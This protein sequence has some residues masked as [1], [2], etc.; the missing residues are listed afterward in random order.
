MECATGDAVYIGTIGQV[1]GFFERGIDGILS[2]I[3]SAILGAAVELFANLGD[4]PTIGDETLNDSIQL[5]TN[6]LVVTIAVASLLAAA[7][8]M[9]LERKGQPM[10]V[11][12]MGLVRMVLTVSAAWWVANWLASEADAYSDHLY[13]EGIKAQLKLIANCGT[14][15]LTAFLLI[16]IG[17]LLLIAGCI[18]VILMYIRLGVMVLLTGTLPLAAAASMSEW[19][20]GWWRK[21]IA[22]MVA[23]LAF[24]PV[25]GL[26]MYSGAAMIGATGEMD[27]TDNSKHYKLAGAAVLLMAAVAL[28]ALMR[29]VVPAMASLGSRDGVG[30]GVSAGAAGAGAVASGAKRIAGGAAS[31][32]SA[33]KSRGPSGG[34][35]PAGGGQ[36]AGGSGGR[37]S[38]SGGRSAGGS[39]GA[40]GGGSGGG[41]DG[42]SG[43]GS[44]GGSR[45]GQLA[46]G[47]A[48]VV[49]STVGVAASVVQKSAK[50]AA[51]THQHAGNIASG[52]LPDPDRD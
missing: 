45:S 1:V 39:G 51:S 29:L 30:A 26:I 16:I 4:I 2:D 20:G 42:G 40:S 27:G 14:D 37:P 48:G 19:G 3:A 36:S 50:V 31:A 7:F 41:S 15:G 44:G 38:S 33:G 5:Q 49:A 24:K 35:S 9:A 10:V 47:A 28:P 43:G 32:A 23:W 52:A 46:R 11:A 17:L 21:H 18:H 34:G 22:W 6:W 25:V 8:R 12:L 13:E